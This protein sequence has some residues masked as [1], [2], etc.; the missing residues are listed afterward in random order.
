MKACPV[1]LAV[2]VAVAPLSS[3][4]AETAEA[5]ITKA[6][7]YLGTESALNAVT[8]IHYFGTLETPDETP[9]TEDK[10]KPAAVT[11]LPAEIVVQKPYQQRIM[12]TKDDAVEI[13]ALDGYD[14]W[15]KSTS[16]Q[17]PKQWRFRLLEGQEIK[18][19]RANTWDNLNFFSGLEKKGGAVQLG[20]EAVVDGVPCIKL[21]FVY[22]EN[23]TFLRFFDRATGRLVRTKTENG[24][25]I[26]EEGEI[27]AGGI[28]FPRKIINKSAS[29]QVTVLVID[30]VVLNER[31][32][33]N[34]FAV[35]T[36]LEN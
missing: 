28:R 17:T 3:P 4:A 26:R 13:R 12:L 8:S 15:I 16:V 34:E 11:R 10:G 9:V 31:F 23:I 24:G 32:P 6:R 27:M 18:Q 19:L 35:P 14:G 30:R 33:D 5:W 20:D 29:G 1:A 25:E 7:A 21:S 36:L 2:L 22:A